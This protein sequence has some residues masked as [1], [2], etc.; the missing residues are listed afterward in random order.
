ME[1]QSD[2]GNYETK[3]K[4]KEG[5]AWTE[6]ERMQHLSQILSP[7]ILNERHREVGRYRGGRGRLGCQARLSRPKEHS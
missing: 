7:G 5:C 1:I 4:I 3:L 6:N 2:R